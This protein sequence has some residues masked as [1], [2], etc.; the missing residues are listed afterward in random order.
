MSNVKPPKKLA[1]NPLSGE[2]ELITDNNFSYMSVPLNKR[3]RI[4][5]N[6]Q[7][8]VFNGFTVDGTLDLNGVLIL[9]P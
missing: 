9:E 1:V 2:L 6:E 4:R 5:T 3:L 7:M 8:V